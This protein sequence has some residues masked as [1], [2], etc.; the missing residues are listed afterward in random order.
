MIELKNISKIYNKD[1]KQVAALDG[2]NLT[3]QKGEFVAIVGTSGSGKSTMMNIMGLLDNPTEGTYILENK[4][5]SKHSDGELAQ[6]R[7]SKIGFVFQSFNLLNKTSALQN[8]ELPLIYSNRSAFKDLAIRALEKVGLGDRL[9]HR[10]E[11]LSGGQQQRVAIARALVNEPEIIFADEPTGNL[12]SASGKEVMKMFR[13]L[14]SEGKT[15]VLITHDEKLVRESE[16]MIRI[17]DGKIIDD[18]I[19]NT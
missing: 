11:E 13:Q 15:I 1:Q 2:V 14:H 3:I 7:N 9:S 5:V 18:K 8:V 6:I 12:D 10:P 4:D 17:L 19:L 16:R